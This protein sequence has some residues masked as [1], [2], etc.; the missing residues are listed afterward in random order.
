M[1]P[2]VETGF[3]KPLGALVLYLFQQRVR[4]LYKA[5]LQPACYY[6]LY[7]FGRWPCYLRVSSSGRM[8][9]CFVVFSMNVIEMP[10]LYRFILTSSTNLSGRCPQIAVITTQNMGVARGG[11]SWGARDPPFVSLFVSKQPTIFR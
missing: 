10:L 5:L 4:D 2:R 3:Y 9:A 8:Q 6:I 7:K 11:G 1:L